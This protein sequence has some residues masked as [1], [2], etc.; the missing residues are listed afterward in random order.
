LV[1]DQQLGGALL[2]A[3]GH[4]TVLAFILGI[5][6]QWVSSDARAARRA[7]RQLDRIHGNASTI[8]PWWE[9][10]PAP[11]SEIDSDPRGRILTQR[12]LPIDKVAI[13]DD[14]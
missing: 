8:R 3:L 14:A 11:R 13:G 1:D 12:W 4:V 6:V 2:W 5:I 9:A 10:D 7:D